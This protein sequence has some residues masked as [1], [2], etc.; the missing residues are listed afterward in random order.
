MES[1]TM[2]QKKKKSPGR[3]FLWLLLIPGQF[4]LD[5]LFMLVAVY[6]DSKLFANPAPD[7]V[8]HPF[9][10]ITLLAF[11]ALLFITAIIVLLS[12]LLTITTYLHRKKQNCQEQ[13]ETSTS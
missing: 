1:D 6:A 8:G 9:P 7:A 5:I 13:Q 3:A 2:K 10:A 12:I 11:L 4:L